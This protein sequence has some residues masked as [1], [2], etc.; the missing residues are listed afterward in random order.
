MEFKDAKASLTV[1][2]EAFRS[3]ELK[4]KIIISHL[5]SKINKYL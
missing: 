3:V 1:T 5:R 4:L 2:G